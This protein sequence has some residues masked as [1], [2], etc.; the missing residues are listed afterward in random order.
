MEKNV[1]ALVSPRRRSFALVATKRTM[2]LSFHSNRPM[3]APPAPSF[4]K[5]VDGGWLGEPAEGTVMRPRAS[6]FLTMTAYWFEF[7]GSKSKA[8]RQRR[9]ARSEE[10]TSE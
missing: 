3:A 10:H 2:N 6:I 9:R 4:R 8:S 7:G 1:P 5:P